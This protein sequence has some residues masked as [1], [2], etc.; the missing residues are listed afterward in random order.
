LF[1]YFTHTREIRRGIIEACQDTDAQDFGRG[2][3]R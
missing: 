2:W 1:N 3:A